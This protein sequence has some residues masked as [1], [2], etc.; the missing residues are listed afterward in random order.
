MLTRFTY[1]DDAW[2]QVVACVRDTFSP[3]NTNITDVDPGSASHFEIMIGGNPTDLGFGTNVGGVSTNGCGNAYLNNAVVFD[4]ANVWSAST[5]TCGAACIEDICSTA[6]QEIGHSFGLDHSTN[7]KDPMTYFAFSGRRYFQNEADTCGSDCDSTGHGPMGNVC[8]NNVH[9]CC[10]PSEG[11]TQNSYASILSLFG[12]GTPVLPTVTITNPKT[13]ASVQQGFPVNVSATADSMIKQVAITIDGAAVPPVL[14][15]PPFAY[16]A[17]Q[18]LAAGSHVVVATATDAHGTINTSMI[19]VNIGPPCT[20]ASECPNDT[21]ACIEG[22]CVPGPNAT[23]GLG[24][25]CT[26]NAMCGDSTCASDG[27]NQYCTTACS[28]PGA[29]PSGFG[30]LPAANG[31]T[32]GFCWPGYDDGTGGGGCNTSGPGGPI[33]GGLLFAAVLFTRRKKR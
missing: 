7:N 2:N 18:G 31:S 22:R 26:D 12:P 27:N 33:T 24:T 32:A 9:T 4:F 8:T 19:T 14:M 21:D 5:T 17:P 20:S 30:C 1:G 3:F 16:N 10:V 11:P 15:A 25:S 13:G 23:G 6:A 29:C 28:A